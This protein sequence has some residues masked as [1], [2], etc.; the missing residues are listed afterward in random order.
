MLNFENL[1]DFYSPSEIVKQVQFLR[2]TFKRALTKK[3]KQPKE[4]FL[5]CITFRKTK[6]I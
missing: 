3:M 1:S 5:I 2:K 4:S 6:R